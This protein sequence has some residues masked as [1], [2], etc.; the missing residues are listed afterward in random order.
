M[1]VSRFA[2]LVPAATADQHQPAAQSIFVL[3]VLVPLGHCPG[4][5]VFQSVAQ[6]DPLVEGQ[7]LPLVGWIF[8]QERGARRGGQVN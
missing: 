3:Q 4:A 5:G 2:K 6:V 1:T 7:Q 8:G